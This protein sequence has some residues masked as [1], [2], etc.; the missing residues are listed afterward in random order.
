MGPLL[1]YKTFILGHEQGLLFERIQTSG[2][3][4]NDRR[5][6]VQP[7]SSQFQSRAIPARFQS[8]GES[9][10]TREPRRLPV[11]RARTENQ[12][13]RTRYTDFGMD[14]QITG[15]DF[16]IPRL[17]FGPVRCAQ[18]LHQTRNRSIH[19]FVQKRTTKAT[20]TEISTWIHRYINSQDE[21]SANTPY[22][23]TRVHGVFYMTCQ[24]LFYII[25]FRYKE[26][27]NN[28]GLTMLN[29]INLQKIVTC[30]LNP[31][32]VCSP[33]VASNFASIARA[34]QLAY[35]YTIMERNQR[36]NLPIVNRE[37]GSSVSTLMSIQLDS[38]FP[39]DP[40]L[41]V[42]FVIGDFQYGAPIRGRQCFVG[43]FYL[44]QVVLVFS[45]QSIQQKSIGIRVLSYRILQ[46][47]RCRSGMKS[48]ADC[49]L[50]GESDETNSEIPGAYHRGNLARKA[51]E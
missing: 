51:E 10:E 48:P 50:F 41:L 18:L 37:A 11:Q 17:P 46:D 19:R 39:F 12:R 31:L 3:H 40:Y 7:G 44:Q 29:S 34:Y 28:Q 4:V 24:A 13:S 22:V 6:Q 21:G 33:V 49:P 25:G 38:F 8:E 1:G 26:L 47:R 20:I 23:D 36:N 5:S 2:S 15:R 45:L 16:R 9:V 43:Q 32:R 35:C 27:V 14:A 42:R 30:R